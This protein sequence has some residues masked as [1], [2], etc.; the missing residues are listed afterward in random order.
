MFAAAPEGAASFAPEE[1]RA[2]ATLGAPEGAQGGEEIL[3]W[4]S[5]CS[6]RKEGVA[7]GS[8]WRM[9]TL[10]SGDLSGATESSGAGK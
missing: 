8:G 4:P 1:A 2:E 5:M 9:S 6:P 3:Y 7:L 10:P